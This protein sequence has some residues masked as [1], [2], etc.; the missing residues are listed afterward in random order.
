MKYLTTFLLI[1]CASGAVAQD[2]T[3]RVIRPRPRVVEVF[4]FKAKMTEPVVVKSSPRAMRQVCVNG[5]CYLV[6]VD[7]QS[8]SPVSQ[9]IETPVVR[10]NPA[11]SYRSRG[12]FSRLFGR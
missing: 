9:R 3:P 2:L 12:F 10:S 5:R 7:N 6:P 8:P 1:F 4:D 11:R